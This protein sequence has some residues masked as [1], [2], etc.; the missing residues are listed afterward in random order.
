VTD[1]R[2]WY[3]FDLD[4]T[5]WD[6][7]GACHNAVMSVCRRFEIPPI[8]FLPLF[9]DANDWMWAELDAGNT[10]YELMRIRRFEMALSAATCGCGPVDA[11]EVSRH[12][13]AEYLA[14]PRP[15]SGAVELLAEAARRGRVAVL[16]NAPHETQDAKLAHLGAVADRVEFML[17]AGE[18]AG[19][20][21][22]ES[23]FAEAARRAGNPAPSRIVMIGDSWV[24]DV[25]TPR[26]LGWK[27]VWIS[28]GHDTPGAVGETSVVATPAGVAEALFGPLREAAGL[29]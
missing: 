8:S 15:L 4:G 12:Y 24:C 17:C 10:D 20:K 25:E 21:P 22:Q 28:H 14:T 27:T 18:G 2:P 11:V 3:F 26:R 29:R 19:L 16:T 13:V 1:A 7:D 5:L 6:H 23:F 9:K